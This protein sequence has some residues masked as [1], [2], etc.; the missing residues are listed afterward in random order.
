VARSLS[1]LCRFFRSIP[2][3]EKKTAIK[4]VGVR[5]SCSFVTEFKGQEVGTGL[6]CS[7]VK[8]Y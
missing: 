5:K 1:K 4:E 3:M 7:G 6:R 2:G 8:V